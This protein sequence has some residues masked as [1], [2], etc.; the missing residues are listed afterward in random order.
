[1]TLPFSRS[2]SVAA[3]RNH[4]HETDQ[5]TLAEQVELTLIPAPSFAEEARGR[6]LAELMSEGGLGAIRTDGVGN[7]LGERPGTGH[8]LPLIVSAHLDTVFPADTELSVTREG[9]L[10]RGPG[11]SDD[12][13]GLA[14]LLAVARA[15]DVAGIRT[16]SSLLFVATVGEEG[17]GDLR[18]VKHLFGHEGEGRRAGGFISLDGA[19]IDRVIV[20]GLGSRRFRLTLRGP[21]G[22]SWTDWG[23]ANP[24]HTLGEVV[25]RLTA[26]PLPEIPRTTLTVARWGG[27]KSI[28]AIPEAAWVEVDTRSESDDELQLLEEEIRTV[29]NDQA[30]A[31]GGG[32]AVE[33]E[34]IGSRPGGKT[35]ADAPLVQA[36]IE[37]TH[38]LGREPLLTVSSTDANIPM[39]LG[40]PAIT[41]GAGGE[42]G[43]THTVHEWYRNTGGADGVLRALYLLLLAAGFDG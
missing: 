28:N 1:M 32:L 39:S 10:L 15:F 27:G 14:A 42:A 5:R 8:A 26:L 16:R 12:A 18:G 38:A 30:E 22:H 6:R 11:I 33:V 21:G 37:A 4:I 36:A 7:V 31:M 2:A 29:V 3:A 13:R 9:E 17:M 24:I 20:R 25:Q 40:I 23:T 34:P 41:L 35:E 19:G 43:E